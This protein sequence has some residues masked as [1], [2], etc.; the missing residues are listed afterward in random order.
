MAREFFCAYHS[1]LEDMEALSD[2]EKGRLFTACLI[3]SKTGEAPILVGNERF[4]FPAV[5]FNTVDKL[6]PNRNERT[7]KSV[8]AHYFL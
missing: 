6:D 2:A 3:Y 5:I 7:R 1:M 4:V 8:S